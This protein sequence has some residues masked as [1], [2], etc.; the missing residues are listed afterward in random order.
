MGLYSTEIEGTHYAMLL[1]R[2]SSD[3][4]KFSSLA[5]SSPSGCAFAIFVR[6]SCDDAG[7]DI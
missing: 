6:R 2:S 5:S 4:F 1:S 3:S 7:E